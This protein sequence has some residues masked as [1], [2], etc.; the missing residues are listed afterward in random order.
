MQVTRFADAKRYDAPKH[1]DM[2]SLRLQGV[3]VS[4][5]KFAWVGLSHFLPQGG[6]EMDTSPLERIYV[7][8]CGELTVQLSDGRSETL[9]ALDSCHIP[10]GEAR[11]IRNDGNAVAS[12]LVVMPHSGPRP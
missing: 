9:R 2:R 10:G 8:L 12:M 7:V 1:F 5:S 4:A 3:E 6:A 11:A